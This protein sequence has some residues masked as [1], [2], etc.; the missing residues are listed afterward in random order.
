MTAFPLLIP[1]PATHDVLLVQPPEHVELQRKKSERGASS[2]EMD[3]G[4][5]LE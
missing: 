2:G 1:D 5:L 3:A 4:S